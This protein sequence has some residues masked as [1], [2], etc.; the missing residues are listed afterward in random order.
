[1]HPSIISLYIEIDEQSCRFLKALLGKVNTKQA[2]N[3]DEDNNIHLSE[4]YCQAMGAWLLHCSK[5]LQAP[6][7]DKLPN[8]QHQIVQ[9][10]GTVRLAL[11]DCLR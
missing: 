10:L 3:E 7:V 6:P 5:F 1:M 4:E 9:L 11:I 2:V 8:Q